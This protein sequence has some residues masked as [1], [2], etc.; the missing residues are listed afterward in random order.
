MTEQEQQSVKDFYLFL[1]CDDTLYR[2]DW[3]VAVALTKKINDYTTNVLKLPDGKAYELYKKYGTCLRGLQVE[4]LGVGQPDFDTEAMLFQIHDQLPISEAIPPNPD[5]KSMLKRIDLERVSPCVFTASIQE[6]AT[7]CMQALGIYD[8]F[9]VKNQ[10]P[11]IDVRS[12]NFYTKHDVEALEFAQKIVQCPVDYSSRCILV[13]DS[14]TNIRVAKQAGWQ[15]V[16]VGHKT[17]DGK[18]QLDFEYAD[19][20]IDKVTE[21]EEILPHLFVMSNKGSDDDEDEEEKK[22]EEEEPNN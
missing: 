8:S 9:I 7:R 20:V 16:L 3:K 17:R 21:L 10:F 18:S 5:L 15:T 19:H 12:V 14:Q 11:I 22:E 13:D 4:G 1:D 6:H 2:D